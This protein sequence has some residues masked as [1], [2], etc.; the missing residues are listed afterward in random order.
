M[1]KF[2]LL[3]VLI[4]VLCVSCNPDYQSSTPSDSL[5]PSSIGTNQAS[6]APIEVLTSKPPTPTYSGFK[7]TSHALQ[8]TA[9]TAVA[10]TL[11]AWN[12]SCEEGYSLEE[13]N[14][15]IWF[16]QA[17]LQWVV[18]TCSPYEQPFNRRYTVVADVEHTRNWI[19]PHDN[20]KWSS[21]A[22]MYL[23]PY[24]L[25]QGHKFLYLVPD[26]YGPPGSGFYPSGYFVDESALYR[27]DLDT[28]QFE[29]ILRDSG[30]YAIEISPDDKYLAYSPVQKNNTIYIMDLSTKSEREI[31]IGDEYMNAGGFVWTRDSA[32]V[33]FAGGVENWFE[34]N[35]GTS[36]F[37]L[38]I[39]N[40]HLQV[41]IENDLRQLVP[42][43]EY[44]DE[45][46]DHWIDDFTLRL[47][48]L[49]ED[50][51]NYEWSLDIR[52]GEIFQA[53]WSPSS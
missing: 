20:F 11:E 17:S 19:I 44:I 1:M 21:S 23:R 4:I 16:R 51:W 29:T 35:L 34:G 49:D 53:Q 48:S 42:A 46:D 7:E 15:V 36:I 25:R 26:Y 22:N 18:Y 41:I 8:A 10:G 31:S 6:Q 14:V 13:E 45:D 39:R 5:S 3:F 32:T 2:Q 24:H 28:G 12:V 38:T 37:K 33:I 50:Y 43:W 9:Q 52:S 30:G 47:D 40:M 27:I